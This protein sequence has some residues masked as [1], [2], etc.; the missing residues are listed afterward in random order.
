MRIVFFGTP[1]F[2]VP[3]LN[4][5]VESGQEIVGVFTQPDKPKNRG[6][7]LMPTPVKE[8]AY[9]YNIPV[10][11][12]STLRDGSAVELLRQ[13]EPDLIVVAAYGKIL[14]KEVLE[15]PALGCV[16]IHSSLLPK[17]RGAA[18]INWAILNGEDR[19]GVTLMYMAEGLD[20]GDMLAQAETEIAL[21]ED[22]GQLHDQLARMGA[23]LL[24]ETLPSL[25][26]G[27]AVAV[28]QDDALSCYAPMLSKEL[29]PVDWSRTARQIHD[30]VRGLVP[31][32]SAVTQLDGVRCKLWKTALTHE[33]TDKAPGSVVQADKRGLKLA[34]GDGQVLELLEVQ[35]DGKKRMAASAFLAGHPIQVL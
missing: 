25:E 26:A 22:A 33:T 12:P 30:Q 14:P 35:P 15:L 31:W 16:N 32:P 27:T 20:T 28:P 1:D 34:C 29:S 18:P 3:A 19:T 2:A 23:K 24:V 10:Y 8:C 17:Y 5:L 9:T 11:Q 6:M 21:D 13:L 7:K 4:A